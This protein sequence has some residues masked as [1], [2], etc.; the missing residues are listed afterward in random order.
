MDEDVQEI[1][2]E[3]MDLVGQDTLYTECGADYRPGCEEGCRYL[4]DCKAQLKRIEAT[5]RIKAMILSNPGCL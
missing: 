5:K 2:L 4:N 1:L 3:I